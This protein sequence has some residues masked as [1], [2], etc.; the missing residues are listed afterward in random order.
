MWP[1]AFNCRQ[2]LPRNTVRTLPFALGLA[3]LLALVLCFGKQAGA[4]GL[5]SPA[6]DPIAGSRV[7]GSKG[8]AKCH[9]INGIGSKIGPDLAHTPGTRSFYDLAA[10]MWNHVPQMAK[11]MQKL[12][13]NRPAL[14]P[15]ETGDLIAFLYTLNYFDRPG[16]PKK[17]NLLFAK[18]YCVSCHQLAGTGGVLGPNLDGLAQ[19]GTPISI[20][21]AMW[22]HGPTMTTAMRANNIPRPTFTA[23]ELDDL[24]AYIKSAKRDATPEPM[25]VLPGRPERG[26]EL[27]SRR[28]CIECHSVKGR[29]GKVG[30]DLADRKN[31]VSLVQFAAAMWNKTP[32]M[33]KEMG[34]RNIPVPQLHPEEMADIVAYLYSVQYF[35]RPG[36]FNRGKTLVKTK[37]CL[38]C[39]AGAPGSQEVAPDFKKI[40][41]LDQPVTVVAAMWNHAGLMEQKMG[42]MALEWPSLTGS[43]MADVVNYIQVSAQNPH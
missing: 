12:G 27:F 30:G 25:Y 23:T 9:S 15:S 17:G 41:H 3:F 11:Q 38:S 43:E 39:H 14:S 18:K 37:N 29:G 16:D 33:L 31:Q 34:N 24:I 22:N 35:A 21:A 4:Q 40:E 19:N 6:Q 5:F 8:C 10:A 42:K 7:F 36:D 2:K 28:S 20:S 32:L 13:I 26:Q 1:Q